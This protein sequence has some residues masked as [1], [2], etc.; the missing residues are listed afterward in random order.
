MDATPTTNLLNEHEWSDTLNVKRYVLPLEPL[1]MGQFEF[2]KLR[3]K[4]METPFPLGRPLNAYEEGLRLHSVL[5]FFP[6]SHNRVVNHLDESGVHIPC[7]VSA[8]GHHLARCISNF[9]FDERLQNLERLAVIIAGA[10]Q[11]GL[12]CLYAPLSD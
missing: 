1:N 8:Y 3:Q 2:Q 4:M 7:H 12:G 6:S 10:I 9:D 5:V 11:N